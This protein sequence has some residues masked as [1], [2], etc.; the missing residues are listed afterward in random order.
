MEQLKHFKKHQPVTM[1]IVHKGFRGF[2]AAS[3]ASILGGNLIE[4]K[5]AILYDTLH[6][7]FD[8]RLK[9]SGGIVTL[10]S[11]KIPKQ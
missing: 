10:S 8:F 1:C 6:S 11:Y 4:L 2:R 9:S 3:R 5:S 7:T